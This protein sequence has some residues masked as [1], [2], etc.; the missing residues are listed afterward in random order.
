MRNT[1]VYRSVR[2]A[3]RLQNPAK[4][5]KPHR[6]TAKTAVLPSLVISA[7]YGHRRGAPEG[8]WLRRENGVFPP[9]LRD[10][11]AESGGSA[12]ELRQNGRILAG[13]GAKQAEK[14]GRLSGIGRRGLP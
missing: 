6:I 1:S 3:S 9:R 4:R 11:A 13:N 14:C 5:D 7:K 10:K 2:P 12:G 8:L